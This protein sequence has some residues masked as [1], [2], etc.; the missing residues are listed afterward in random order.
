MTTVNEVGLPVARTVEQRV[1]TGRDARDRLPLESLATCPD[2]PLDVTALLDAEDQD[3]IQELVPLR[4]ERMLA[5]P[6][7][8]YRGTAVVMAADLATQQSSGLRAQLCGDAHLSNFGVFAT[9]ERRLVL[10]LN[11]FDETLPGPFEWDVKRLAASIALAGRENG[12]SPAQRAETVTAAMRAYRD[13]V[14]DFAQQGNLAVWY[15]NLDIERAM[16]DLAL[17]KTEHRRTAKTLEKARGRDHARAVR[18]LAEVVDGRPRFRSEPPLLVPLRD[19]LPPVDADEVRQGLLDILDHYRSTLPED[20]RHLLDQFQLVDVARKVVGV[21]SVGT[22]AWVL[23]MT[24]RD[25][26]DPLLLQAKEA[27][28]SVL[29]PY[30]GASRHSSGGERVVAGQRLLQASSD[31]FLGWREGVGMDGGVRQHYV[32]QLWDAKASADVGA[33]EPRGLRLYSGLCAWTLARGHARSGDR[34]AIASYLGKKDTFER[35]LAAFA[36]SYADR[37]EQQYGDVRCARP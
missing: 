26:D 27:G 9:P 19:L 37:V 15:A 6:F 18:K 33:M 24:G 20:R 28:R 21:G 12:H 25:V 31:I 34:V 7:A 1:A 5:S 11:D 2:Q 35:A 8:F 36:E 4:Y 22:R 17:D 13:A 3:R 32:R 16:A 23:L 10:D 14:R 29:E 30:C